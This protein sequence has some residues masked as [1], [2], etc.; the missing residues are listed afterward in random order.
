VSQA[1]KKKNKNK[2]PE[3]S[4]SQKWNADSF[5]GSHTEIETSP[6]ARVQELLNEAQKPQP[7]LI[8]VQGE[9]MG[10]V[11][12]LNV[13]EMLIGRHPTCAI[14]LHQ[15]AVSS[16]HAKLK[17][18]D[19]SVI[20]EDSN[21]TNG[22]FLNKDKLSRAVVLQAGDLVKVGTTVL[23]YVDSS[24]EAKF[25][26]SLHAQGTRDTLTGVY[27]KGHILNSLA[28]SIDV[29]KAGF[30]LSVIMLDIDFF[31]KINDTH[32][33]IAGDYVLKE[34]SRL[35]KDTVMRSDD[36][37]GRFGGEEF[38]IILPDSPLHVAHSIAE[39]VRKTIEEHHF[40]FQE[41]KIPVTASLGVAQWGA[42]FKDSQSFLQYVDELL[43]ESKKTAATASPSAPSNLASVHFLQAS[44][45]QLQSSPTLLQILKVS[46]S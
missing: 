10:K 3:I 7:A 19:S 15:R 32:G 12:R 13:G 22:T 38:V 40:E 17:I 34:L 16:Y 23:K 21:S 20:I 45:T 33:H 30:S 31:K 2:K 18:S 24:L 39:R 1:D 46:F 28:S 8:V 9:N 6:E 35:L 44:P 11:Y 27:N 36:V 29:A 43:Y 26:E 14:S 4:A 42:R 37:I 25:T 41:K 5:T